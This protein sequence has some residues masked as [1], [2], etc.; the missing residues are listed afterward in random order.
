[1]AQLLTRE[2]IIAANAATIAAHFHNE[3]PDDIDKA[4]ALYTDDVVWEA[5]SRGVVLRGGEEVKAG[6]LNIFETLAIHSITTLRRFATED[7]VVDDAIYDC[8][9]IG[10][11]MPNLRYDVGT[12]L[13]ARLVHIFE[14]RDRQIARENVYE[15]WR[16]ADDTAVLNDDIPA[17]AQIEVFE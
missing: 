16:R 4:I 13:R 12:R 6:Y 9:V 14:M 7:C 10:A 1:M 5:A 8:T 17:G 2:E 11:K 15:I 3:N